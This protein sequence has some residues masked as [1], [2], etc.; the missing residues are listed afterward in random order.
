MSLLRV[1]YVRVGRFYNAWDPR[2]RGASSQCKVHIDS[3]S[4]LSQRNSIVASESF[5]T[6]PLDPE[7][8]GVV[9]RASPLVR[10]CTAVVFDFAS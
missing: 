7:I 10:V 3:D 8:E 2:E 4:S 5:C 6:D 1:G 9:H